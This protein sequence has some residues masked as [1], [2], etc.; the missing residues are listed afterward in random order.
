MKASRTT[1]I[2]N[3]IEAIERRYDPENDT[4]PG[5]PAVTWADGQLLD[6]IERLV[7]V[8][9]DLQDQI[10]TLQGKARR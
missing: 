2:K 10:N 1:I 4:I 6:C 9:E 7:D 8:V 3:R 5:A